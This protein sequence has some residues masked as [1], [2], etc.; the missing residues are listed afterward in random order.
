MTQAVLVEHIKPSSGERKLWHA[1]INQM[2]EDG[3]NTHT[4]ATITRDREA[5]R[6]W[7][8]RRGSGYRYV[9]DLADIA[10]PDKLADRALVMFAEADKAP[11]A[12][13]QHPASRNPAN[14]KSK[15]YEFNGQSLTLREWSAH[16]GISLQALKS[17]IQQKWPL[18]RTFTV[19][20]RSRRSELGVG[21]NF[22]EHQRTGA[23][24]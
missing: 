7:F 17:R 5:A 1:V 10:D 8:T 23:D 6:D 14:Y 12:R 13:A 11:N 16:T 19:L 20:S 15:R 24:C 9:C 3:L 4:S 2:L 18:E 21:E 22:L